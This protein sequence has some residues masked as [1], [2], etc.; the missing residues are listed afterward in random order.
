M[1]YIKRAQ[2]E[3]YR[4]VLIELGRIWGSEGALPGDLNYIISH[5]LSDRIRQERR[6]ATINELVGVLECAKLEAYRKIASKY[7]DLKEQ[8]NGAVYV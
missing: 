6:Y 8:E 3:K 2:R 5:I 4:A 1:P 7:E